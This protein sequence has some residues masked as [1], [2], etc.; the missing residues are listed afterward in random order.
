MR[1]LKSGEIRYKPSAYKESERLL[2]EIIPFPARRKGSMVEIYTGCGWAKGRV[3]LSS[4]DCCGIFLI[5]AQRST[6]CYD[7]RNIRDCKES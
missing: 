4:R 3:T 7:A 5:K 1:K 2:G 6:T